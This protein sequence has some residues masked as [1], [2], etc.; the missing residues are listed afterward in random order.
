M[1]GHGFEWRGLVLGV[2]GAVR[3][4]AGED[5]ERCEAQF[6]R[7]DTLIRFPS[8]GGEKALSPRLR[9]AARARKPRRL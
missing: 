7:A 9:G 4:V 8:R 1:A 3:E 6:D 2:E 5:I